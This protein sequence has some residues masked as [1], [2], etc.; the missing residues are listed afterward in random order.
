MKFF[1]LCNKFYKILLKV[2]LLIWGIITCSTIFNIYNNDSYR[3][4]S[5]IVLIGCVVTLLMVTVIYRYLKQFDERVHKKIAFSS[6]IVIFILM[7]LWGLNYQVI[8]TYDLSHIIA[9]VNDMLNSQTLIFGSSPYFSIYPTQIPL[10]ILIYGIESIGQFLGFSNPTNLMII[11]N[12][13]MTSF[14]LYVVYKIISKLFNSRVALIGMFLLALYPDFYLF[15]SYYYTDI[16]SLPFSIIGYYLLVKFDKNEKKTR[17][18]YLLLAGFIFGIGTRLRVVVLILL[19]AYILVFV[20]KNHWKKVIKMGVTVFVSFA[21]FWGI[22]S[23]AIYPMFK[24]DIDENVKLPAIHWVMMGVNSETDGGYTDEDAMYSVLSENKNKDIMKRLTSRLSKLDFNFYVKKLRKVWST[25]DHDI[26]R[27]YAIMN[28]YD[29][30]H[31]LLIGKTQVFIRYISQIL[32]ASIYVLFFITICLELSTRVSL[33]DSKRATIIISVFGAILFYLL[34]EALNRYSFS[35]LPWILISAVSGIELLDKS[36]KV[37]SISIEKKK[38]DLNKFKYS[39]GKFIIVLVNILLIFTGIKCVILKTSQ[40]DFRIV[41]DNTTKHF[42]SVIDEEIKEEFLVHDSFNKIQLQMKNDTID[43]SCNYIY[44]IYDESDKL[45]Y[46]GTKLI[47]KS[48]DSKKYNPLY[49]ANLNL[50]FPEI[51]VEDKTKFYLK[52]YSK[53]ATKSNYISVNTF[54]LEEDIIDYEYNSPEF[55]G[56]KYDI[57]P[58]G[59]TYINNNLLDGSLRIKV[60]LAYK[61]PILKVYQYIILVVIVELITITSVKKTLYKK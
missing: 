1:D 15:V 41:Q 5:I 54:V 4:S 6:F 10:T 28:K 12:A 55:L 40:E 3:L 35:F 42:V 46:Q 7:L 58:Y 23:K 11:Y 59:K 29:G 45:L 60:S 24:V 61:A 49:V 56:S 39:C 34:W 18:W 44:E 19:I 13:F 30:V 16:I 32:K 17:Y 22:Y 21:L 20:A 48:D 14:S 57:N 37:E 47:T 38:I 52:F 50:K 9:K 51:K 36:L 25:G 53:E 2:M 27:K 43:E 33:Q 26:V 8:P 31:R